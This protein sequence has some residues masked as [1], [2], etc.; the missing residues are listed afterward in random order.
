MSEVVH[1]VVHASRGYV[2]NKVAGRLSLS[3]GTMTGVIIRKSDL[4]KPNSD[5]SFL[6]IYG[7]SKSTLGAYIRLNG[8]EGNGS[9]NG[10]F[11]IAAT[12]GNSTYNLIGRP[13][14]RLTWGEKIIPVAEV[15]A[16]SAVVDGTLT[17]EPFTINEL[18]SDG[19]AFNV[20]VGTSLRSVRDCVLKVDCTSLDT[21]PTIRW[22]ENFHPRTDAA[23]DFACVAG[24]VNVYWITEYANGH[25]AVAGWQVTEGGG[26][27]EN[28]E[29]AE[30]AEDEA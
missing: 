24:A 6:A 7:A 12:D 15:F 19:S 27:S 21:A 13:N 18:V 16:S 28:G 17:L 1:E 14:G 3:G 20:A 23:T 11:Q 26:I 29:V 30:L 5:D 9:K 2:D 8:K 4:A 10:G 22:E 25:F